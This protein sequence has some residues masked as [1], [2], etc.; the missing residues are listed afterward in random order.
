MKRRRLADHATNTW[1]EASPLVRKFASTIADAAAGLPILDVACGSG[2]N[3]LLL[4]QL[5]CTVICVDRDLSGLATQRLRLRRTAAMRVSERLMLQRLDLVQDPWPFGPCAVGGIVNVHFFLP[6]L[7]PS[8]VSSLSPG[9][10]LLFETAPGCGGNYLE[11]PK[12]GDV[13][14]ALGKAF[15]LEFYQ[16][17][18]VGPHDYDAVTVRV[19]ARRRNRAI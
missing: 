14:T 16:E 11:L 19:L 10:Y 12:A 9:G 7:F 4:S 1:L 8:F 5:G 3:A 17:G 18:K 13:K 2:R 15:D 6:A